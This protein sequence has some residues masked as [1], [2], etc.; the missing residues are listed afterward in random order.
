MPPAYRP[1][2]EAFATD[3]KVMALTKNG[4]SLPAESAGVSRPPLPQAFRESFFALG[5][6]CG[7]VAAF[8]MWWRDTTGVNG[9]GA[10]LVAIGR[11]T[12]LEGTYAV[13]LTVLLLARVWW[14]DRMIGMDRLLVWHRWV[15]ET[16]IWLLCV[17]A[18][19]IVW[20]Y[21]SSFHASFP[22]ETKV[23]LLDLPDML[24]ATAGLA[25][26]VAVGVLSVRFIRKKVRYQTWYFI[27]LYL[28]L[29]IALS[30]AHQFSTGID[31]ASH[32][33]NRAIWIAAYGIVF[34]LLGWYRVVVPL[35]SSLRH[36]LRVDHLT[37]EADGSMSVYIAGHSLRRLQAQSGQFFLWRFLTRDGWWQAHPFSLSAPVDDGLLR[38]T[39]RASGDF[40]SRVDAIAVGSKV[41]A[42]GPFGSFT[43]RR[44][45]NAKVLLIAAGAG[46]A[47]I[48]CLFETLPARPGDLTLVYR[49]HDEAS[50][51]L[52]HELDEI[53][54]R[55]G[56][57]VR[58]LVGSR[59]KYPDLFSAKAWTAL[60]GEDLAE[61]DAYLCGPRE[62]VGAVRA[63]LKSAGVQGNRIYLER[64]E[65]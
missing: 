39:V 18:F 65:L 61:F 9:A 40:T 64:F 20:G 62:F 52:R 5:V 63:A 35:R 24:T 60:V 21:S 7:A 3:G 15:G 54:G 25:L 46:I 41:I 59:A 22:T 48:R 43:A 50:L 57:T 51:A 6:A 38:L 30:F 55:R 11:V 12:A 10:W 42:E 31:F 23:V 56:A 8:V 28:Y 2:S 26:F 27:H 34:G 44:R 45:R 17:H 4:K 13:L 36:R 47:P 16:A 33:L 49:A 1:G 58:Y 29:A 53:A 37:A 14:L 32:P 19:F